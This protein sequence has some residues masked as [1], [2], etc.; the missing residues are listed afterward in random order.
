MHFKIIVTA[1]LALSLLA[2]ATGFASQDQLKQSACPIMGGPPNKNMYTD[3]KGKRIYFCCPPCID[4]FKQ[5]PEK[6]L[7]QLQEKG[8]ELEDAPTG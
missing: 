3:Y 6:Y 7:K 4:A 5:D 8:V 2:P 1:L